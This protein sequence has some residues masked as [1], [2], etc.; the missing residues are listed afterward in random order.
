MHH[1]SRLWQQHGER[2]KVEVLHLIRTGGV[3]A[4]YSST[5]VRDPSLPFLQMMF[6]DLTV[7]MVI[8]YAMP[9]TAKQDAIEAISEGLKTERFQHR[10][11]HELPFAEM[12][13]S[14]QLIEQSGSD[15]RTSVICS[16]VDST[17]P[18]KS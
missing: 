12:V 4:T 6:M 7:R 16:G 15:R 5:Q 14:H 1:G 9:E 18:T 2:H 11:G 13:K 3:I 17:S 10:I 8:V